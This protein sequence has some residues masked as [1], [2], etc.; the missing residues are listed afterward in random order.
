M[1]C[2]ILKFPPSRVLGAPAE[3]TFPW[4]HHCVSMEM[5]PCLALIITNLSRTD[6]S[7]PSFPFVPHTWSW[8]WHKTLPLCLPVLPPLSFATPPKINIMFEAL[9]SDPGPFYS[10]LTHFGKYPY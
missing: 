4:K 10:I 3:L 7:F 5:L 8:Q 9:P 1:H 6:Y 2:L